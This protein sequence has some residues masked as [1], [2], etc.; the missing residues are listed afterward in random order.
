MVTSWTDGRD[1]FEGERWKD[2]VRLDSLEW[3]AS[4]PWVP[5]GGSSRDGPIE[6]GDRTDALTAA[7]C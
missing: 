2:S 5:L 1:S 3:V 6:S 7:L 4:W